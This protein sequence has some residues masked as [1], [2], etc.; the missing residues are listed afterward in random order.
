MAIVLGVKQTRPCQCLSVFRDGLGW[1]EILRWIWREHYGGCRFQ[2]ES[3]LMKTNGSS[4]PQFSRM[5]PPV[6]QKSGAGSDRKHALG[7]GWTL[8][9]PDLG[10]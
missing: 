6:L 4:E 7:E 9:L 1:V 10:E 5:V 3:P 2:L 8:K